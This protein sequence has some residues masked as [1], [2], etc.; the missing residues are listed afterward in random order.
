MKRSGPVTRQVGREGNESIWDTLIG[1]GLPPLPGARKRDPYWE[2]G[3]HP[4]CVEYVWD[5]LGGTDPMGGAVRV[6]PVVDGAAGR[7]VPERHQPMALD[8]IELIP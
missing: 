7:A 1:A 3:S 2:S 8:P 6:E 5:N 4:D